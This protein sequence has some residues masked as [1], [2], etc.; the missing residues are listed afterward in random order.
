MH[1]LTPKQQLVYK[2]LL[3]IP[4]GKVMTYG[5]LGKF[6]GIHPRAVGKFLSKN[7]QPD[8]YP[9]FKVVAY[10]GKLNGFAYGLADKEKRLKADGVAVI[11]GKVPE[12]YFWEFPIS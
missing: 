5:S 7:T 11:D 1:S 4:K 9:C 10:D 12:E 2:T 3:H 8:M 6:L